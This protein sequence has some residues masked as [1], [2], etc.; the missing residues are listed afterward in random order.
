MIDASADGTVTRGGEAASVRVLLACVVTIG[1]ILAFRVPP[2]G[3]FDEAFHWRRA[4]QLSA[5]HPLA[6]RLGP[7]DWGGRLDARAMAF[8]TQ[9]D[10][11]IAA[12]TPM[13]QSALSG[14]LSKAPPGSAIVSFPSTASFSPLPYVP[15]ALGI[16]TARGLHLG[17]L[18]QLHAGRLGN[19]LAYLSLVWCVV[20][21]LPLGRLAALAL[22]T[23]PTTLHLASSFSADP[24]CNALP[25]LL[26]ACCLRAHLHPDRLPPRGWRA[27]LIV[28]LVLVGLLKPTAFVLS[29]MVL[30]VPS[31]FFAT[32]R[33]MWLFRAG[34]VLACCVTTAAWNLAYPF[35]PG[36]YWHTGAEPHL[37]VQ[38]MLRAPTHA[39]LVLLRNGW[40][41]RWFWWVDGWGRYGGG[42]GPYHFTVPASLAGVFLS[43][44]VALAALDRSGSQPAHP[45]VA[46][47]LAFLAAAYV[48]VLLLA[49]RIG[50]GPPLS[51]FIDGVQ[52]RY[53][54]LPA[55]LLL[56]SLAL[57]LPPWVRAA[58]LAPLLLAPVLLAGCLLPDLGA[59]VVA[60]G[61][62]AA[63]WH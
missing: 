27:G 41:D 32:G 47:W 33:G 48:V 24:L 17:L 12:G 58:R 26:A 15:A 53:L 2:M 35:V 22:L 11:A 10:E 50:Y 36:R 20:R 39:V 25:A 45:A 4:L 28:L 52:G 59:A 51:D 46:A 56:L 55:L 30:L 19:L 60:L 7:N 62:Y 29:G 3:G 9:A 61:H 57:V 54:L 34:G 13:S 5:L 23:G 6:R 37:A 1:V 18:S 63:L 40:N 21:V 14:R 8:E 42:P 38:A 43:A 44:V 49:F 16:A 31:G